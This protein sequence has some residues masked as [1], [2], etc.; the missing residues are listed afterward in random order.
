MKRMS[1]KTCVG[2]VVAALGLAV[3][4]AAMADPVPLF[5]W[6]EDRCARWDV[7]DAP[8][9]F[10]RDPGGLVHM[11]A[12][13]DANR[14]SIGPDLLTLERRC[15]VVHSGREDPAPG[16]R[17]DR[18][19]IAAVHTRDGKHIEALGHAEYHGHAH[20][21]ACGAGSYMACWRNA[22]VALESDDGG[23]GFHRIPGPPVAALPYR[24][25]P[26]QTRR[27]G[28]FNPS[29][30]IEAGGYLHVFFFAEA[31]SAQKRGVCLARRPLDGGPG[32]W[33]GWDG[34]GFSIRFADPYARAVEHPERHVCEPLPGLTATL[35]T[36]VRQPA[37]GRYLAVSP[38]AAETGGTRT[39]GIWALTS[40]DLVHWQNRGLLVA[41]PLL[42]ARDC[43]AGF[44]HAYPALVDPDSRARNFDTVGE[45][46][47]LTVTRMALDGDC[48]VG[49]D[50]DL[51]RYDVSW[52]AQAHAP[53]AVAAPPTGRP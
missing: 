17:D 44:A 14:L 46:F 27:S 51:V 36:V 19:W 39:A 8:A 48:A 11:L 47:W 31:Y 13:N 6:S 9:R 1:G 2:G 41:V 32:D 20:P 10:W 21:G 5:D 37:T 38:M 42:W 7:P 53:S 43:A 35:S 22:I 16:A 15:D 49:P 34:A 45:T 23:R 12:G 50:R 28:Y 40:T 4:G 24:Y 52:P 26:G 30:M 18:V 25:D 33:R 29:N 3:A